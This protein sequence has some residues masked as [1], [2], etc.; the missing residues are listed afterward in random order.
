MV[1]SEP[2]ALRQTA[3]CKASPARNGASL[4]SQNLAAASKSAASS[5]TSSNR[6][7]HNL[8]NSPRAASRSWRLIVPTL[9]LRAR[10]EENS[11]TVQ[12][13]ISQA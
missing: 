10:A 4:P 13:L 1:A 7:W 5:G 2:L 11:V 3:R 8:P 12:G 6:S 9:Y